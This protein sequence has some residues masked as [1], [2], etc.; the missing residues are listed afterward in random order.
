VCWLCDGL[1]ADSCFVQLAT[2]NMVAFDAKQRIKRYSTADA[3]LREFYD[4]RLSLYRKRKQHLTTELNREYTK[5]SN[6]VRFV[7]AVISGELVVS[8]RSKVCASATCGPSS[9]LTVF[10]ERRPNC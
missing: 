10:G 6:K 9:I 8:K 7:L 1:S 3:I 2:T 5:L 4:V